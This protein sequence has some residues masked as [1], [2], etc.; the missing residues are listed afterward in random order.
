MKSAGPAV[1]WQAVPELNEHTYVALVRG[2]L[3][4]IVYLM[5]GSSHH[6][7]AYVQGTTARCEC[8]TCEDAKRA[9]ERMLDGG[10]DGR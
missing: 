10:A 8:G 2:N 4:A 5:G 3:K 1:V 9:A 6:W 7:A